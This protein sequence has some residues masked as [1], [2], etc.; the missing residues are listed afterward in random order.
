MGLFKIIA[1]IYMVVT[2]FLFGVMLYLVHIKAS[3]FIIAITAVAWVMF[4]IWW[5]LTVAMLAWWEKKTKS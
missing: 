1:R 5:W 2:V 3:G 4:A